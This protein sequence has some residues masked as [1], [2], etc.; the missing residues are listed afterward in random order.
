ML[1]LEVGN[2]YKT[3]SISRLILQLLLLVLTGLV[4]WVAVDYDVAV[5]YY[6]DGSVGIMAVSCP[7]V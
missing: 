7:S 1:L 4:I 6:W 5:H 3:L 2:F